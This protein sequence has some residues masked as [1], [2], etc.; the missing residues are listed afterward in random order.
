MFKILIVEDDKELL[1]LF[2]HVLIRNGYEVAEARNG[3][4]ALQLMADSYFDLVISDI[5]M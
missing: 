4:E 5:M 1:R 2:Q 3:R